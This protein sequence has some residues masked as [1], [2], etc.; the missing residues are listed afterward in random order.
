MLPF[1]ALYER[2]C[3]SPIGQIEAGDVKPLKI[4]IVKEAQVR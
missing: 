2:R 1:K 4:D 3:R